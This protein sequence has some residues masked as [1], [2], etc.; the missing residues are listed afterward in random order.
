MFIDKDGYRRIGPQKLLEHRLV[1][2]QKLGRELLP[3]EVVHHVNGD[4]LDNRP[5]NLEVL[6][7]AEHSDIHG[8]FRAMLESVSNRKENHPRWR[9]DITLEVLLNSFERCK[10]LR[11]MQA[12]LNLERKLISAKLRHYGYKVVRQ[13]AIVGRGW[14]NYLEKL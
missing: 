9:A 14:E 11:K 13:R 8:H 2:K 7:R 5:E 6:S 12:E 3:E 4:R 10:S 1:M